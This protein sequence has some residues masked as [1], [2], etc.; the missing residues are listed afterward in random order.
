[1]GS[2]TANGQV[3]LVNQNGIMVGKDAQINVGS[4]TASTANISNQNFMDG[5]MKFDQPGKPDAPTD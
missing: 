2:L 5:R 1:M 3:Y 4:L